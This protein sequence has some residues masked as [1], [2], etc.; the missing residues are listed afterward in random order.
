MALSYTNPVWAGYF[1]DPF[2]LRWN[3]DYFAYGTS[4]SPREHERNGANPSVFEI[5]CSQNLVDW[6]PA[7]AALVASQEDIRNAFWAPEVAAHD[8]RFFLYY[9]SAP[10]GQ[11]ELHRLRVAVA[12]EPR[13]PFRPVGA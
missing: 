1:A 12:D 6:T 9:S 3:S 7:G 11:D 8:G 5:L 2:V 4:E 10:V 13:G